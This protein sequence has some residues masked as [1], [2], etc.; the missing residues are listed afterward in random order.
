MF[1]RAPRR[2]PHA[3]FVVPPG[4]RPMARSQRRKPSSWATSAMAF[5]GFIDVLFACVVILLQ[6][7]RASGL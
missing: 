4:A 2:D 6:V 7:N 5:T 1:A 3:H